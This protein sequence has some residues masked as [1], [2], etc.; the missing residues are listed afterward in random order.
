M[1]KKL[2]VNADGFGFTFGNNKGILETLE[3]GI[4][5][6]ISTNVNFPA[7]E[8][9][10]KVAENF[11]H[12]SIGIHLNLTAGRPVSKPESIL[13]LLDENGEALPHWA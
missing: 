8:E 2:I 3:A 10:H 4:V 12:V 1:A 6:S 7:V 13:S 5:R 9:I 11:P